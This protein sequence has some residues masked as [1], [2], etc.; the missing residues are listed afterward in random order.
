MIQR[1][2]NIFTSALLLGGMLLSTSAFAETEINKWEAFLDV[3]GKI[4]SHR[5][6]GEG[7]FFIPL[8]QDEDTLLYTDIRYRLDN[9][10][11]KEG[12]FGLG[13]RHILPSSW[14]VGG[15]TYYDRRKTPYDNYFSQITAGLELLSVDWDFRANVYIPIGTTSHLED[16]LS[17]VDF[18]GTSIMYSQGEERSMKG[19]DV[20]IGY[21]LPIFDAQEEQ[22]VRLFA[23]GYRFYED[24]VQ[25]VQGPRGRVELT[26]DEV[27]FLWE[28]SRLTLGAE[29]QR[30]DV[31]GRQSFATLRIR[32]PF[33]NQ[34]IKSAPIQKL[35]A[36]E[37]RMTTPIIRDVDI[38]SQ[39]GVF[40]APV[41][42]TA[43]ADGNKLVYIKHDEISSGAELNT[44]IQNA[45]ENATIVLNGTLTG[46]NSLSTMKD[47]QTIIGKGNIDITTPAGKKVSVPSP[48]GSI[49][50]QGGYIP[51]SGSNTFFLMGNNTTLTGITAHITN[52]SGTGTAIAHIDNVNNVTIKNSNLTVISSPIEVSYVFTVNDSDN[53]YI[54]NNTLKMHSDGPYA[55]LI[56][57][58]GTQINN[59][60]IENYD[61]TISGTTD[62][63]RTFYFYN[64]TMNNLNGSN[65]TTNQS[66]GSMGTYNNASTI[67]GSVSFTNGFT[68][69]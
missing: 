47:G 44:L 26:F 66:A 55:S 22:Q 56:G 35:S 69:Q 49:S 1:R 20:E 15:Y 6:L 39:A 31:R 33:G 62:K 4:G 16:S 42:V 64:V 5:H 36:I 9:Q 54:G 19:Y 40:E 45:G 58:I 28:G 63:S 32:I 37:K 38:V 10:S 14:I 12:N 3:E 65:N 21:R 53:I 67:N 43:T 8:V 24:D 59:V 2:W 23:G 41:E 48:G 50:G 60:T 52:S 51:T 61:Y 29:V 68:V 25:S 57:F 7:D 17:S 13:L 18:S 27:P 46:I 30:D 11:S 34:K